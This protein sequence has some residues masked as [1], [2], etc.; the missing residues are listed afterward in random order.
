MGKGSLT[1]PPSPTLKNSLA[2][3][4]MAEAA[5]RDAEIL[6]TLNEVCPRSY[7]PANRANVVGDCNKPRTRN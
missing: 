2:R 3:V 1:P 4:R 7:N 6:V 5:E